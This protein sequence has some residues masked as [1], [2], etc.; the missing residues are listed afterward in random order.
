MHGDAWIFR[1]WCCAT[2][3]AA[4]SD[5]PRSD[6]KPP[7]HRLA[8]RWQCRASSLYN[9][10]RHEL[11]SYPH[12]KPLFGRRRPRHQHWL[13]GASKFHGGNAERHLR[14]SIDGLQASVLGAY[15][16]PGSPRRPSIGW[17]PN[18]SSANHRAGRHARFGRGSIAAFGTVCRRFG[19]ML[20]QP[21]LRAHRS[22][23]PG[24]LAY[25]SVD[26]TIVRWPNCRRQPIF[27]SAR[28]WP[29][30]IRRGRDRRGR[31]V[32]AGSVATG[33]RS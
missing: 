32:A 5:C 8:G 6:R 24:R 22:R 28:C 21:I 13:K 9:P 18:R 1:S 4:K 10:G 12:A 16:T 25:R 30:T 31:T 11:V 7:D 23:C 17:R 26:T 14:G 3:F 27:R 15:A 33:C 2:C 19:R 29:S 20:N